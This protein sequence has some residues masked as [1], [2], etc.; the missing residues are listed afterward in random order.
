MFLC[1]GCVVYIK[2]RVYVQFF[3]ICF[4]LYVSKLCLPLN[5]ELTNSAT[6]AGQQASKNDQTFTGVLKINPRSSYL[7]DSVIS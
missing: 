4:L 3:Y 7:A 6:L 2:Y 1:F 5:L